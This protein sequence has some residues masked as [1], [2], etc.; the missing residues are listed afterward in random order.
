MNGSLAE[1]RLRQVAKEVEALP[2]VPRNDEEKLAKLAAACFAET[3]GTSGIP[4][5]TKT[6]SAEGK[7]IERRSD[8]CLV[9]SATHHVGPVLIRHDQHDVWRGG[10]AVR[11]RA[12]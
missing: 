1:R 8:D 7:T 5:P 3:G 11:H 10:T 4:S 12:S 2:D 9:A 6:V